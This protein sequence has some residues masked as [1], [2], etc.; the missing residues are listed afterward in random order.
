MDVHTTT[1]RT[2]QLL[3]NTQRL[4]FDIEDK[5]DKHSQPRDPRSIRRV[6]QNEFVSERSPIQSGINYP[7]LLAT[8]TRDETRSHQNVR[9]L[10]HLEQVFET[11]ASA[12]NIE[13][14]ASLYRQGAQRCS[15]RCRCICHRR[16]QKLRALRLS[17]FQETLGAFSFGFSAPLG[18][19][20]DVASCLNTKGSSVRIA[21]T[22]PLWLFHA[23]IS[24]VFTNFT[25]SPELLLRVCRRIPKIATELHVGTLFGHVS[26][27][28]IDNV[29][30]I[31]WRKEAC[32][33]D[34]KANTG[35]TILHSVSILTR[36][37][38]QSP[39]VLLCRSMCTYARISLETRAAILLPLRTRLK[40]ICQA[41]ANTC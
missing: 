37:A 10:Q 14:P 15:P 35:E 20:C 29:K 3:R 39:H 19:S 28:E 27:G 31:L 32:V 2:E 8:P 18:L 40:G 5:V 34:V 4:L 38:F 17:A 25:T 16:R 1:L 24:A 22:F 36:Y 21:Y 41:F 12:T 23:T 13:R 9:Q 26:R 33:T 7:E 11:I 30:R 6:E